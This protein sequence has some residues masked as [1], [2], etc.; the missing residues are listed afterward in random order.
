MVNISSS[1]VLSVCFLFAALLIGAS[2]LYVS[3]RCHNFLPYTVSIFVVGV[4][5]AIASN[6]LII[7][8]SDNYLTIG[9]E[10]F[11]NID[12]DV[13]LGAFLPALLFGEAMHLNFYQVK[14]AF[15]SAA[16][17]ALPG[18]AFG[19]YIL[20]LLCYYALPDV[21][22]WSWRLCF[23]MGSILSATDPVS[24]IA[25]LK[26]L[27]SSSPSTIKLTYIIGTYCMRHTTDSI[28]AILRP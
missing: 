14:Q 6:Q 27:S 7:S 3:S 15:P 26:G 21:I 2:I 13:L 4:V 1:P 28:Y 24:V 18:A 22:M 11:E 25:T 12:P 10:Q 8:G 17:L 9:A 23:I 5:I 16:L 19:A 20:A